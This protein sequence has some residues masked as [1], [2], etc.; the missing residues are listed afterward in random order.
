MGDGPVAQAL[1]KRLG[2]FG[3][4]VTHGPYGVDGGQRRWAYL[5]DSIVCWEA[6]ATHP[7]RSPGGAQLVSYDTMTDCARGCVVYPTGYR[8]NTQFW[9]DATGSKQKR[10][11]GA[12]G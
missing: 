9:V 11:R 7:E 2:E 3:W 10:R 6:Q 5:D 8:D 4:I 1:V 12:P